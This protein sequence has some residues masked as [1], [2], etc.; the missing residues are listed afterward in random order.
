MTKSIIM[1]NF[2]SENLGHPE[3]EFVD[4]PKLVRYFYTYSK[5][6]SNFQKIDVLS[7]NS[8]EISKI[9]LGFNAFLML[10]GK[11]NRAFFSGYFSRSCEFSSPFQV[12]LSNEKDETISEFSDISCGGEKFIFLVDKSKKRVFS[13]D[14]LSEKHPIASDYSLMG[15]KG[16][17]FVCYNTQELF[18]DSQ[19]SVKQISCGPNCV[20]FLT[21]SGR[22]F[23]C[24]FGASFKA[25]KNVKNVLS[26]IAT[27]QLQEGEF[28]KSLDVSK[29]R[30]KLHLGVLT[31]LGRCFMIGS[32]YKYKLGIYLF[33]FF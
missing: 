28:L 33:F 27:P 10:E 26:E 30:W 16:V 23:H 31:N 4:V 32:N 17:Q 11:E 15:M 9:S 8:I 20:V 5:A 29:G 22:I 13:L 2:F 18:G 19:E 3:P 24:E 14:Q 21:E 1:T 6:S 7:Q 25:P 12:V